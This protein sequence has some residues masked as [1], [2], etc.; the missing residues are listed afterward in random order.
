MSGI[1]NYTYSSKPFLLFAFLVTWGSSSIFSQNLPDGFSDQLVAEHAQALTGIHF[2]PNGRMFVWEKQ[3]KVYAYPKEGGDS[4]LLIDIHEEVGNWRD[5]GL[6]GFT[7]H[8]NFESNGYVYLLYAVDRHYLL[9]EG[10]PGYKPEEDDYFS[11]TIGRLT[12][13]TLDA[14]QGFNKLIPGSRKVLIGEKA[15]NGIPL[16]HQSH[17]VGSLV[18]GEDGTL[19]LSVG[20]AASY[21]EVD[22]GQGKDTSTYAQQALADGI[23]T[24]EENVGSFRSQLLQSLNGKVLRIDPETGEGIPSNPFFE[25]DKPHSPASKVWALGM[26]NPFRMALKPGSGGHDPSLAQPGHLFVGDV[27]WYN[28][29]ELN[30]ISEGG[31]N[32][33]WPLFEGM[34]P[35]WSYFDR[36][37]PNLYL[38][39]PEPNS[40][41]Q[42]HFTFH[43]LI[44]QSHTGDPLKYS[45]P[46]E[47]S[48]RSVEGIPHFVHQ[49]PL[50]K[51]S[52]K[53]NENFG[54]YIPAYDLS[55]K[56]FSRMIGSGQARVKGKPFDGGSS[57]GG[58][59]YAGKRFPE[60]FHQA[61]FHGDF[62]KK[63]IKAFLFD[64][65]GD[66]TEVRDFHQAA[67]DVV[68]I[69]YNP[70]DE[71]L[72]YVRYPDQIRKIAY[73][74][75]QPPQAV[76][77]VSEHFGKSPLKVQ[78][79]SHKS[80][81]P[82]GELLTYFWNFGDGTTSTQA[83]P[84]HT[85]EVSRSDPTGLS[86][87]LTVKDLEGDS[88]QV[89]QV[90]SLNNTPP[91]VRI[92]SIED[93]SFYGMT[94][95]YTLPLKAEVEDQEFSPG[96]LAYTWE[97]FF[98]HNSHFHPEP[99]DSQRVSQAI[100]T[101]AGCGKEIYWYRF[102][103]TVTDPAGLSTVDEKVLFPDCGPPVIRFT[104]FEAR[105]Q[106]DTGIRL[107]WE[108][109]QAIALDRFEVERSID[110]GE[111]Y[112]KLGTLPVAPSS[113][114]GSFT[115]QDNAPA[116]GYNQ[117]RIKAVN[118]FESFV[119]SED[120]SIPFPSD[121]F[122]SIYPNPSNGELF[123]LPLQDSERS[124]VFSLFDLSGRRVLLHRLH[125]QAGQA[126]EL[127]V[128]RLPSGIYFYEWKNAQHRETGKLSLQR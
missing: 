82:D 104:Q 13:Y 65:S 77:E 105:A 9:Y 37:T 86:I 40:C 8:P 123:L 67:G 66:L 18:F 73:G 112:T 116:K 33:G 100:I 39:I 2:S 71:C 34:D 48:R 3:G 45:S 21:S 23:L 99:P 51:W 53:F 26:R 78:F 128:D 126:I 103:L 124:T 49:P 90:I 15:S 106:D 17:G 111:S 6:L 88:S 79:F 24:K 91:K 92:S 1:S 80:F 122:F 101:P 25:A 110:Q 109:D 27:G 7:L 113:P 62:S 125:A 96:E 98:H 11:A 120:S 118:R 47:V 12:R 31:T 69:A 55:G 20:D 68:S 70:W 4:R 64:S 117:Y 38:P 35:M 115:Y 50:I 22:V 94:A 52:N 60:A 114:N 59:F 57:T 19:L 61:Y 10:S 43:D 127:P 54:A 29:E 56:I 93:S 46:C 72:Y 121:A 30:V 87:S 84:I 32:L 28:W 85:F 83:N 75:N 102:R 58:V 41:E 81:D 89:S 42:R 14:S 119:L 74:G 63:W 36:R 16:I 76:I 107:F 5:H 95:A 44:V 108:Y 97:T